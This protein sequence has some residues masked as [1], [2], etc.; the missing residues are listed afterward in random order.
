MQPNTRYVAARRQLARCWL[1]MLMQAFFFHDP[2][3]SALWPG[4]VHV[5]RARWNKVVA[6]IGLKFSGESALTP[7]CLRAGGATAFY[8]KYENWEQLRRRG[9]W[10]RPATVEIYVQE[11]GPHEFISALPFMK[12]RFLFQLAEHFSFAVHLAHSLIESRVYV[13]VV[14]FV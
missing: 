9:R 5:F 3:Q 2:P 8:E 7:G 6:A 11:V 10:M 4:S 1:C 13:A 14:R 12:K